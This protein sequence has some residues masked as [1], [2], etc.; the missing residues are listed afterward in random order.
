MDSDEASV[1]SGIFITLEGPDGAGKS[2]QAKL[3]AERIR[4]TEREVLLTREPGGTPL[5]ERIRAI[6]LSG[7]GM[8]DPVVDALLFS[9]ARRHLVRDVIGPALRRGDVVLCDRYADS[10]LAY[11]GYGSGAP[12]DSL[13]ALQEVATGGLQPVRTV[14]LDVPPDAGLARRR[15][16]AADELTR[17][18]TSAGY[19]A[20]FHERVRSGFLEL[21]R[22][23]PGRWRIVDA[24]VEPGAVAAQVWRAVADLFAD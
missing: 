9:A 17:F 21:A 12:L 16:G 19:E 1:V 11:Q 24:T 14:L 23:E 7:P 22:Q 20:A 3:L 18:E 2:T 8:D 10:T 15:T 5:G 13:R 6:L 4:V